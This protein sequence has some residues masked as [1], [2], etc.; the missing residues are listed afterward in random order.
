VGIGAAIL[1]HLGRELKLTVE[2][3]VEGDLLRIAPRGVI[4]FGSTPKLSN[5]L[6]ESLADHPDTGRLA[7]DLGGVGRIDFTGG[8]ALRTVVIDSRAAGLD[9]EFEN[10]PPHA[11][12]IIR[13]VVKSLD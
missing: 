7:I 5:T 9:V 4:F 11:E 3:E 8:D 2:V 6:L 10:I 1:V 13:G 12:R